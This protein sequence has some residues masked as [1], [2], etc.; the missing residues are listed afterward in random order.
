MRVGWRVC[1]GACAA[2]EQMRLEEAADG[3]RASGYLRSFA[4]G[5]QASMQH[6]ACCIARGTYSASARGRA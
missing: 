5:E 4:A 2:E 3:R 6:A 1:G